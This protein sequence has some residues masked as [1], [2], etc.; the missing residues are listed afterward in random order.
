MRTYLPSF[1]SG[2]FFAV[3]FLPQRAAAPAVPALLAILDLSA[4]VSEAFRALAPLL[5]IALRSSGESF[6]ARSLA[7]LTA[8]LF[9]AIKQSIPLTQ[10][11][12]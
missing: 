10:A 2:A 6:F 12:Y 9:F 1:V 8:D 11:S 7:K 5:A 3:A 4:G